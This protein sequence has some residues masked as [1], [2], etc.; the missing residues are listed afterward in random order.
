MAPL[1][2]AMRAAQAQYKVICIWVA[3]GRHRDGNQ[4]LSFQCTCLLS[5]D[6]QVYVLKKCPPVLSIGKTLIDGGHLFV[7]D[8]REATS[9]RVKCCPQLQVEG[10]ENARIKATRVVEYVS[11]LQPNLL[12]SLQLITSS[13][14]KVTIP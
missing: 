3:A 6:A 12:S 13:W 11:Q 2:N 7:W 1:I 14:Q 9:S 5:K 10:A 4:T 8:L